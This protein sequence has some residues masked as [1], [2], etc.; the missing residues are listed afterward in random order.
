L[1]GFAVKGRP[2]VYYLPQFGRVGQFGTFG[3]GEPWPYE[4]VTEAITNL[5]N[6]K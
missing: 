1:G 4:R 5:C 3:L 2:T 6:L